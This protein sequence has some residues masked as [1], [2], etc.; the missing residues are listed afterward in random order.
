[1]RTASHPFSPL[2]TTACTTHFCSVTKISRIGRMLD[3]RGGGSQ[4][5]FDEI[6][7]GE[8]HQPNVTTFICGR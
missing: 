5:V 2:I 4:V 1:M 7:V 6:H 3:H 8:A